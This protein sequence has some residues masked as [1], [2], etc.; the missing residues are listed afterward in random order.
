[1]TR[2]STRSVRLPVREFGQA[3]ALCGITSLKSVLWYLRR[4]VSA[5]ALARL[6]GPMPD[7]I[8]HEDLVEVAR[9][10]GFAVFAR[11]GGTIGELRDFLMLGLPPIVGWW[12]MDPGDLDYDPSW[13]LA[14]RRERDCGHYSVLCGFDVG[15]VQLMDPQW[16]ERPGRLAV[17]GRRWMPTS[18]FRRVW[19]DTDTDAYR[20]VASWYMVV[21]R[22]AGGFRERVGAGKDYGAFA[23][24]RAMR[25]RH[26]KGRAPSVVHVAE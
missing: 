20:K 9:M 3:E 19:Y 21:H 16:E 7:G 2:A 13:S 6:A 22:E 26:E 23:V 8:D 11:A 5:R 18:R 10:A 24:R 4:R 12:S 25:R 15:R 1:M 17:V 14:E